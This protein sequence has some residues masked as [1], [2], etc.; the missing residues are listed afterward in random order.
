MHKCVVLHRDPVRHAGLIR[1]GGDPVAEGITPRLADVRASEPPC[2][3]RRDAPSAPS[4]VMPAVPRRAGS[5]PVVVV[6][7]MRRDG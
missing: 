4:F 3:L 7:R 1:V 6:L 2:V 5:P